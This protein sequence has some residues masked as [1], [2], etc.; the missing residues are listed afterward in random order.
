MF[1]VENLNTYKNLLIDTW[2]F[3][4]RILFW[5]RI[6]HWIV[7]QLLG[8]VMLIYQ[9]CLYFIL[10]RICW[11]AVRAHYSA[12]MFDF[13][14]DKSVVVLRIL[15]LLM[16]TVQNRI[17]DH[18]NEAVH[19][20]IKPGHRYVTFDLWNR[21]KRKSSQ[22]NWRVLIPLNWFQCR[23]GSKDRTSRY[24]SCAFHSKC[25]RER[26]LGNNVKACSRSWLV[27]YMVRKR[28]HKAMHECIWFKD[29]G[30]NDENLNQ[31]RK[32]I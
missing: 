24:P 27:E 17:Y 19:N 31:T 10:N 12:P 28:R 14:T 16:I 21:T 7:I 9:K 25:L 3:L 2:K 1:D 23:T 4:C 26:L 11:T 29:V 30:K 15:R 13:T 22:C 5:S 18:G 8:L 32:N 20:A 6:L